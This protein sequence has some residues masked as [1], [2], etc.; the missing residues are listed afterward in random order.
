MLKEIV[1][2]YFY[3]QLTIAGNNFPVFE[4]SIKYVFSFRM[5]LL[6][7][8][9]TSPNEVNQQKQLLITCT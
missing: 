6:L 2:T 5:A 8:K 7:S 1:N 9:E 4:H 3:W